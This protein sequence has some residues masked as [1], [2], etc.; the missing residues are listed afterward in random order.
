M[1]FFLSLKRGLKVCKS[2]L[3]VGRVKI[4]QGGCS[5]LWSCGHMCHFGAVAGSQDTGAAAGSWVRTG[6]CLLPPSTLPSR[7]VEGLCW[8]RA[9]LSPLQPGRLGGWAAPATSRLLRAGGRAGM[10][11]A[12]GDRGR[13]GIL[14]R[15]SPPPGH[16]SPSVSTG[17]L[18]MARLISECKRHS[19]DYSQFT[20]SSAL[21]LNANNT[22]MQ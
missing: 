1:F 13:A 16:L 9:P 12:A 7:R 22:I 6:F 8:N 4:S 10:C 18:G 21:L 15:A 2:Y 19:G 20:H 14:A 5:G 11:R 3:S 17:G